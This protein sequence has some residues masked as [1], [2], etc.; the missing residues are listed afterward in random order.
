M[1]NKEFREIQVSSTLLVVIFLGV[2]A[3]G[4]F[5][6]LL[7]VSVGKR[8]TAAVAPTQVVTQQIPEP[9]KEPVVKPTAAE[10]AAGDD[11]AAQK[12]AAPP[13]AATTLKP[14]VKESPSGS[15]AA[16]AKPPAET[17]KAPATAPSGSGLYYV[18]VAAFAERAQAQA[19]A[20]KFKA[21]GYTTAL[22]T[23][24]TSTK[25]WYRVRLG[26]FKTRDQAADLLSKLNAA[27]GKKT[28]YQ[29]VH[30]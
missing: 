6:F 1:A 23:R 25:T 3:L 30:D 26:G 27:A 14:Q 24:T 20:D 11:G 12:E 2:L 18:Q 13:P 21:Q 15:S 8:Q 19:L 7:G 10:T 5:I 4:V 22:S 28:D 9:L 17:R 29:I 16:A